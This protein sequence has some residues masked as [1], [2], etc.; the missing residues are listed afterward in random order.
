MTLKGHTNLI[1]ALAFS[2]DGKKLASAGSDN[3]VRLWRAATN[4]EVRARS[5]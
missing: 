3:T 1:L 5:K 2:P 4:E